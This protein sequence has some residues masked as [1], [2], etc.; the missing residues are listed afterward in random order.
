MSEEVNYCNQSNLIHDTIILVPSISI[1]YQFDISSQLQSILLHASNLVFQ[2]ST[3]PLFNTL[4]DNCQWILSSAPFNPLRTDIFFNR[5]M[6]FQ[7]IYCIW[8]NMTT[9]KPCNNQDEKRHISWHQCIVA[10]RKGEHLKRIYMT[11]RNRE[12]TCMRWQMR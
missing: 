9:W 5:K 8:L 1:S 4:H 6:V 10:Q 12:N 3:F 2:E 11:E 7:S